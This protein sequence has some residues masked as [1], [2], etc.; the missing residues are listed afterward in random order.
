MMMFS[1]G[2]SPYALVATQHKDDIIDGNYTAPDE[3]GVYT[4][5]A[6]DS[7]GNSVS[8]TIT[9]ANVPVIT[10]AMGWLDQSAKMQ[11]N[12][13]GGKPP[14][15]W[16]ATAGYVPTSGE[17]VTYT[18]PRVSN[19]VTVTVTDN[20]NQKSTAVVYVDLPLKADREN[21][22]LEPG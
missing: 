6:N 12:V 5:T 21:I 11:F 18:A 4:L 20:L 8:A 15:A 22:P 16:A 7:S 2:S 14:Y 10:P 13:V 17:K 3:L 19:E 1:G 9:V